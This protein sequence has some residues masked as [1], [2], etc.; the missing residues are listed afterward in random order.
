MSGSRRVPAV[1]KLRH[2]LYLTVGKASDGRT[3]AIC[4]DGSP[5]RGHTSV[6]VLTVEIV[7]STDQASEWFNRMAI[8]KPWEMECKP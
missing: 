6:M 1:N 3:V 4:S 8:E 7:G 5:Q 2:G